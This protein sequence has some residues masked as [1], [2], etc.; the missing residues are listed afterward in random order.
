LSTY[1]L[2]LKAR[3][4]DA[5]DGQHTTVEWCPEFLLLARPEVRS[6]SQVRQGARAGTAYYETRPELEVIVTG[7]AELDREDLRIGQLLL[8]HPETQVFGP[9][10]RAALGSVG[11]AT[12]GDG[13]SSTVPAV[14][15]K[16]AQPPGQTGDGQS[17]GGSESVE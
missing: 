1:Q 14:G 2:R 7:C 13:L 10:H 11:G 4:L 17:G 8:A 6:L 12:S 9:N 3:Q 5:A 15:E 16:T